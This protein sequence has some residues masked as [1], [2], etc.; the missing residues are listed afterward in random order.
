MTQSGHIYA[1]CC[2][3]EVDDDGISNETVKTL[4]GYAVQNW[5]FGSSGSFRDIPKLFRDGRSFG[6]GHRW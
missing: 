4:E 1:I 3:Q 6:S 5:E 2:R